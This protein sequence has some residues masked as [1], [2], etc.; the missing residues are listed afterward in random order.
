MPLKPRH[1]SFP[2]K[3]FQEKEIQYIKHLLHKNDKIQC[4]WKYHQL[5]HTQGYVTEKHQDLTVFCLSYYPLS[6]VDI[7]LLKKVCA[8]CRQI[9]F[10]TRPENL[11]H[12]KSSTYVLTCQLFSITSNAQLIKV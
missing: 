7:T 8:D 11:C 3:P 12:L 9:Q 5:F 4:P 6:T 10:K 2:T 1:L